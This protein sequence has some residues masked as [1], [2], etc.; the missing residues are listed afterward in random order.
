VVVVCL[1][2]RSEHF[3]GGT[4]ETRVEPSVTTFGKP[5]VITT[6]FIP[7]ICKVTATL[8]CSIRRLILELVLQK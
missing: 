6:E 1:K 2:I 8:T 5:A 4:E 7:N 3:P